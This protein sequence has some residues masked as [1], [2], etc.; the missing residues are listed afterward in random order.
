MTGDV[1]E[2]KTLFGQLFSDIARN[3]FI[4]LIGSIYAFYNGWML[5]LALFGSDMFLTFIS[6]MLESR[7]IMKLEEKLV[8]AQDVSSHLALEAFQ[9]LRAIKE[10]EAFDDFFRFY[11]KSVDRLWTIA[12]KEHL[13][14]ALRDSILAFSFYAAYA[15]AFSFGLL[16]VSSGWMTVTEMNRTIYPITFCSFSLHIFYFFVKSPCS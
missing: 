13:M 10:L 7:I 4:L 2:M 3:I 6:G 11:E 16:N 12:Y 9:N 5:T 15:V 14:M 8:A 1:D